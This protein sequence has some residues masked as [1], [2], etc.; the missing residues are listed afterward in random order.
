MHSRAGTTNVYRRSSGRS[1]YSLSNGKLDGAK[2]MSD[3]GEGDPADLD[4]AEER[5][6]REQAVVLVRVAHV[7]VGGDERRHGV[8]HLGRLARVGHHRLMRKVADFD[9]GRS[10]AL[11][12][13]FW[14]Q[15]DDGEA[16]RDFGWDGRDGFGRVGAGWFAGGGGIGGIKVEIRACS[17]RCCD[18]N[19]C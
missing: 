12:A 3:L 17:L 4:E 2:V 15:L 5:L 18:C 10:E 6:G 9:P 14:C 8:E 13:L 16:R 19:G 11:S 7:P 1:L